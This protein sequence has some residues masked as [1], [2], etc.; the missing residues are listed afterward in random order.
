M[1]QQRDDMVYLNS[2][3]C[4][5]IVNANDVFTK[6]LILEEEQFKKQ[7]KYVIIYPIYGECRYTLWG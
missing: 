1:R 7:T 6:Y 2:L 4:L 3:L 5:L